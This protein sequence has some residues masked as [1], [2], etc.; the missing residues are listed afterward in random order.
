MRIDYAI[1]ISGGDWN[2]AG[3]L[4]DRAKF[5]AAV[6]GVSPTRDHILTITDGL[7]VPARHSHAEKLLAN[8]H[9]T[10]LTKRAIVLESA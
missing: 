1:L 10:T 7:D 8:G 2:V 9:G 3:L 5:R 4:T 6:I